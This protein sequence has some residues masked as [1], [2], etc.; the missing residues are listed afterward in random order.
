MPGPTPLLP[1]AG[2]ASGRGM[3]SAVET[4]L[5]VIDEG[6]F[7]AAARRL[8]IAQSTVSRQVGLLEANVGAPLLTRTT[9]RVALTDAGRFFADRARIG[10]AAIVEAHT[11]AGA[12]GV[13]PQGLLRVTMPEALGRRVIVP[14]LAGFVVATPKISLELDL[15]DERRPL[16]RGHFDLA[17]RVGPPVQGEDVGEMLLDGRLLLV[18]TPAW[19]L[20]NP[21][22]DPAELA[23]VDGAIV[24]RGP[25]LRSEW[26]FEHSG[27][28]S[29]IRVRPRHMTTDVEAALSLVLGG[30]GCS[31]LPDWLVQEHL[32]C[33]ELTALCPDWRAPAY[34]VRAIASGPLLAKTA[35]AMAWLRER[36]KEPRLI[37][38]D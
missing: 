20:S 11:G 27:K 19:A 37:S 6:G 12:I 32:R 24:L 8:G 16:E 4:L 30:A 28:R 21:L 26:P 23:A 3:L 10:L 14:M 7:L 29:R 22:S 5:V 2:S 25:R 15:C 9:R 31:L 33:G 38:D 1:S 17:I 35:A 13:E 34:P 18:A 36:M